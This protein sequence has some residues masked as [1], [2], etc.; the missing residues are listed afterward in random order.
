[1]ELY[2]LLNRGVDKRS[3]V[4]DDR[5]RLRFVRNLYEMNNAHPVRNLSYDI[6][7]PGHA[8]EYE[9]E[10]D[11]LVTI[12][13]WALMGNHYHLL[14]SERSENGI[15]RFAQKLNMGYAKYFNERHERS[16]A[17]FQGK[18]KQ[19]LIEND[20]QY[21]Y[22]L[23]YIH[24]NPLDFRKET[25]AWRAQCVANPKIALDV[26]QQYRW[27]SYRNY[28]GE[29]EFEEVLEK[30]SLYSHRS[31]HVREMQRFLMQAPEYS[32]TQQ[33]LELP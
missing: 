10:R 32:S 4:V 3:I 6:S 16:G 30:S 8:I 29:R 2:H 28:T 13:G 17:L 22:I 20:K 33:N 19:I 5:D 27:S 25:A 15:S 21:L 9:R 11:P 31:E 14:V 24:C 1:M 7:N 18:T 26:L 12:H 23:L